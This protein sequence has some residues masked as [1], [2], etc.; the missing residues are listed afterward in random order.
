MDFQCQL[1]APNTDQQIVAY[2]SPLE[3][4]V[5]ILQTDMDAFIKRFSRNTPGDLYAV[6]GGVADD[7]YFSDE[8]WGSQAGYG[9]LAKGVPNFVIPAVPDVSP[10]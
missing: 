3:P 6:N 9:S 2:A 1:V 5:L 4:I 8:L 10:S 7:E